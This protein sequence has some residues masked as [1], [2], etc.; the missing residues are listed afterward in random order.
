MTK[1][2]VEI[3]EPLDFIRAIKQNTRP[4]LLDLSR[5]DHAKNAVLLVP[6][7][8]RV[9]KIKE[10][11]DE[12]LLKPERRKGTITADRLGSFIDVVKR[13]KSKE[14]VLFAQAVITDNTMKAS[15]QA[16]FD[17]HPAGD[18]VEEADN[19]GHKAKYEFPIS[20]DFAFWLKNNAT[21]MGQ[22]DFAL[23]LEERVIEMVAATD[24]DKAKIDGLSPKFA[25]P[26]EML[27]L[28]RDLELNATE[29]VKQKMKLS[30]GETEIAF[31][32]T[33]TDATG[34]P[35]TLPDF[36]VIRMPIFEGGSVE[37]IL[38]RLRYRI[39]NQKVS[40]AYDLYRIDTVLEA[41]FEKDCAY[42]QKQ[43]ELPLFFGK[44]E[45]RE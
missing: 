15:I 2:T 20:K 8:M 22:A 11:L 25:D 6:E 39:L 28:S 23:F 3:Q 33:H 32:S 41:A 37:R 29:S 24:E 42:A 14:S 9:H 35:V 40:W 45:G 4:Q 27:T 36:F 38:V 10:Y 5:G 16:I 44:A 34:K 18:K 7:G 1:S 13:F 19:A 12:Y 17:Y 43:T 31:T 21:M 26:L 30:S